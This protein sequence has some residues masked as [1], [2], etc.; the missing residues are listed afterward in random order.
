MTEDKPSPVP[1]GFVEMLL[2][3]DVIED[4]VR[5]INEGD[6]L[7]IKDGPFA[8]HEGLCAKSSSKR[9]IVLLHLL[10]KETQVYLNP[11]QLEHVN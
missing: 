9:V 1:E 11:N 4:L 8:G 5:A 7:R 3:E 10:G 2:E 6:L